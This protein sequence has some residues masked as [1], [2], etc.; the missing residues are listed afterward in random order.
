MVLGLMLSLLIVAEPPAELRRIVI[1]ARVAAT[2]IEGTNGVFPKELVPRAN[3]IIGYGAQ[4]IPLVMPLLQH[5]SPGVRRFFGYVVAQLP[6]LSAAELV[7][8]IAAYRGGNDRVAP[9]IGSID[10]PKATAFL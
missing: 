8:L 1:E 6:G 5:P 9:A 2:S 3:A 4:A 7:P 10:S